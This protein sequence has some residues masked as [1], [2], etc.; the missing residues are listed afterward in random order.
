MVLN[1]TTA[2]FETKGIKSSWEADFKD[3][4]VPY[5]LPYIIDYV[6][7]KKYENLI[8][9]DAT[10]SHSSL[11][12]FQK[13]LD[14]LNEKVNDLKN[15]LGEDELIRHIGKLDVAGGELVVKLPLSSRVLGRV[16]Q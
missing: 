2:F 7:D 9:V 12:H 14:D 3:F 1:S 4:R 11:Q 10:A 16:Q 8:A 5:K 6:K 15:N 13:N